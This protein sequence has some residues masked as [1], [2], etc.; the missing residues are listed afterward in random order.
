VNLPDNVRAA[1]GNLLDVADRTVETTWCGDTTFASLPVA[2][3]IGIE[4]IQLH[5]SVLREWL[6]KVD[7]GEADDWLDGYLDRVEQKEKEERWRC[8]EDN[9]ISLPEDMRDYGGVSPGCAIPH[10]DFDDCRRCPA[11]KD[12]F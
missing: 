11:D 12:T 9:E 5:T 2:T 3:Q 4:E 6:R 10:Q 1:L 7:E 8:I